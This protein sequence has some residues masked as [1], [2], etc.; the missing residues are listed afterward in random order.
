MVDYEESKRLSDL[1]PLTASVVFGHVPSPR[2]PVDLVET[3]EIGP[4]PAYDPDYVNPE[5]VFYVRMSRAEADE[6]LNESPK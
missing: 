1:N 5:L 3:G 4:Y 2:F 6:L